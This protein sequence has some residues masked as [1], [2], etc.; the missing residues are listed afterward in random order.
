MG[1]GGGDLLILSDSLSLHGLLVSFLAVAITFAIVVALWEVQK[2]A[3]LAAV[4]YK[5]I[6]SC[7]FVYVQYIFQFLSLCCCLLVAVHPC[8][9]FSFA[10]LIARRPTP[11]RPGKVLADV[12]QRIGRRRCS[13]VCVPI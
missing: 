3:A 1:K 5:S 8:F 10:F 4:V 13:S 7:G 12:S 6:S 2:P 9:L 11:E